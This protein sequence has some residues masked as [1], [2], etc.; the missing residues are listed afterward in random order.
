[1]RCTSALSALSVTF[2]SILWIHSP[3]IKSVPAPLELLL[4][5]P[6]YGFV[7]AS[8]YF[9]DVV[10]FILSIPFYGFMTDRG[11]KACVWQ[12]IILSIPFYGF[13]PRP[14]PGPTWL[15]RCW[16]FN[17]ILWIPSGIDWDFALVEYAPFNSILW[18]QGEVECL[19]KGRAEEKTFNSILWIHL[20]REF[21]QVT[22]NYWLS[23]PFYG[24]I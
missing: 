13:T 9:S 8:A 7:Y 11:N 22:E 24:F 1:M 4:S 14:A 6:F 17:S 5:I 10:R 15:L 3:R 19:W 2:N 20:L 23:I 16:P 12:V 21:P 18:I